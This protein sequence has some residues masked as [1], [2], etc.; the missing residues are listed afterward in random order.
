MKAYSKY[1]R[2]STVHEWSKYGNGSRWRSAC[3]VALEWFEYLVTQIEGKPMCQHCFKTAK[4]PG[5]C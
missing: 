5:Q 2:E 1:S 3:G 4:S